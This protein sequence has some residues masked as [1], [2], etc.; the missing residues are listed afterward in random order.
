MNALILCL[1]A[2]GI[3]TI[4]LGFI[5]LLR[6][7]NYRETVARAEKGLAPLEKKDSRPLL[8]WG[9]LLT[10]LGLAFTLGLYLLGLSGAQGYPLGLGPWMLGG[11]VPLFL[12]LAMLLLHFLTEKE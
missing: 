12:G 3:L 10:A 9:I 5:A 4:I 1:G 8:R 11:L 6:Y 2:A 7:L